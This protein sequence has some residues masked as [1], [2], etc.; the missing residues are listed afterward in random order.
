LNHASG[1]RMPSVLS[2][3]WFGIKRTSG[4]HA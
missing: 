4:E 2:V 3:N 1:P